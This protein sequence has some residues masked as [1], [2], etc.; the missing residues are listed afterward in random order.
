M[1]STMFFMKVTK[2]SSER[3]VAACDEEVIDVSL[4][5]NDI[6]IK[7]TKK[8]YGEKLVTKRELLEELKVCT[9]ANVIGT[10]IINLLLEHRYIH[11]E[12]ILWL[13]DPNNSKNRIGHAIIIK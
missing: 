7:A 10:N 6:K 8:F 1:K 11:K 3:L 13:K 9:S 4:L 2:T 5:S 12:A